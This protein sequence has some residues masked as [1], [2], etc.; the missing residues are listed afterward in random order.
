MNEMSKQ[1]KNTG[2]NCMLEKK[3]L[4]IKCNVNMY[5]RNHT[6]L[7]PMHKNVNEK[8]VENLFQQKCQPSEHLIPMLVK[9]LWY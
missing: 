8:I 5:N 9:S 7:F 2:V 4:G 1:R 3:L 6:Q